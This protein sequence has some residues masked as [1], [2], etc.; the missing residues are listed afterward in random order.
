MSDVAGNQGQEGGQTGGSQGSESQQGQ[1]QIPAFS[2]ATLPKDMATEPFFKG[3]EGKPVTEVYKS[4]LEAHKMVGGSV[5]IPGEKSEQKDWDSFYGKLRPETS[6]KYGL[7]VKD[8]K[9]KQYLPDDKVKALSDLVWSAGLHPKQAQAIFAGYQDIL[10]AD[11]KNYEQTVQTTTAERDKAIRDAYGDQYQS[12]A[13]LANR[14]AKRF[15][16]DALVKAIH[17]YQ[18]NSDK[19][20]FDTFVS[21]GKAIHEDSWVTGESNAR[22]TTR[23]QAK[24][25][26]DEI[27][28]NKQHAYHDS[29]HPQHAAAC[30]MVN[31]LRKIVYA[32]KE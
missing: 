31:E 25:Q 13:I 10:A 17:D 23:E 15:G 8:D 28:A 16:G 2:V 5:R 27:L 22:F 24:T 12:A 21:I 20:F 26:V 9:L 1:G 3:F 6:D 30:S 29:A 4:A 19:T 11:V 7:A 18:L 32:P 14:V